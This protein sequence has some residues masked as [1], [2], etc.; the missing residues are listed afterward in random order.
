MCNKRRIFS[1]PLRLL[2]IVALL[3]HSLAVRL[4]GSSDQRRGGLGVVLG[5]WGEN[6]KAK[7][8]Q[9]KRNNNNN[10]KTYLLR[11][12]LLLLL[13]LGGR[14]HTGAISVITAIIVLQRLKYGE[15]E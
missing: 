6:Q 5:L 7:A 14:G 2:E 11:L 9:K 10:N 3:F 4:G 12:L 13:P 1:L 15:E 8:G